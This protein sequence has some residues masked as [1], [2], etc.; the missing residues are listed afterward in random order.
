MGTTPPA[1]SRRRGG[2][3]FL[4]P[5][6]D[7][8]MDDEQEQT[9]EWQSESGG[10]NRLD[11]DMEDVDVSEGRQ[12]VQGGRSQIQLRPPVFNP[13]DDQWNA[14]SSFGLASGLDKL[15]EQGVSLQDERDAAV[16]AV[17]EGSSLFTLLLAAGIL[18]A[19]AA[20]SCFY[21]YNSRMG[22]HSSALAS[23]SS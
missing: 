21:L 8:Q 15:F 22:L 3:R 5:D 10:P 11:V 19:F 18:G 16:P 12:H 6:M 2:F 23:S 4:S 9:M 20:A 17:A 1:I 14:S 13:A 7:V